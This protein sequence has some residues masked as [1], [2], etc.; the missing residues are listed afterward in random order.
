LIIGLN[1]D[2][3]VR[4]IKG[5]YRP[6]QKQA[7]RAAILLALEVVDYV[8]L[9]DE[10]TPDKLIHQVKPDILVKGADYKLSE[11]VGAD[12]VLSYGGKVRRIALTR[13]RSTS[14][15]LKKI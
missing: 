8:I 1:S 10:D 14:S 4:H 13:G 2:S 5:E 11:I 3:S 15:I 9:F 12:F 6:V 7:D